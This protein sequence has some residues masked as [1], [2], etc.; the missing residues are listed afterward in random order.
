MSQYIEN[1]LKKIL[2][3]TTINIGILGSCVSRMVFNSTINKTY[4]NFF[5]IKIDVQRSLFPSLIQDPVKFREEDI[6]LYPKDKNNSV[7]HFFVSRDLNKIFFKEIE[8]KDIDYL[9]ID[10]QLEAQ[11]GI[12]FG[13][14][15]YNENITIT[16]N[17][18]D[19]LEM[20]FY[21]NIK[22]KRIITLTENTE[23]YINLW[24]NSCD[25][26][27][28]RIKQLN[29]NIKIILNPIKQTYKIK[30][31]DGKVIL[32]NE[33]K[34]EC[35]SQNKV[36]KILEEYI[37]DNFEVIKLKQPEVFLNK[38]HMWGL[39][40]VH[41]TDEY[42]Q[43]IFNQLIE[44]VYNDMKNLNQIK[45]SM[46]KLQENDVDLD[47]YYFVIDSENLNLNSKLYG[48]TIINNK[49]YTNN[50][51]NSIF[52]ENNDADGC[53][54]FINRKNKDELVISQDFI[55]SYGIYLYQN[56]DYFAISNSFL[57][58]VEYL[59][60]KYPLSLNDDYVKSFTVTDLVSFASVETMVNEIKEVP[61]NSKI[62]INI[63]NKTFEIKKIDY[64]ENSI[65]LSSPE[66]IEELDK[67]FF[68][69]I[70]LI[71][72]LKKENYKIKCDLSGGFDTRLTILLVLCSNIDLSN[73]RIHSLDDQNICHPEDFEIATQISKKF[74]FKLNKPIKYNRTKLD[75]TSTIKNSFYAK[76]GFHK[77]MY[78]QYYKNDEPIITLS[79]N[80]GENLRNYY[81]VP[82]PDFIKRYENSAKNRWSDEF[83]EPTRNILNRTFKEL[84]KNYPENI[85]KSND[86][87]RLLYR[88][89]RTRIHF[90]KQTAER[91]FGN[92]LHINPLIDSNLYKITVNDDYC[93]DYML[94][95]ALIFV[96]YCPE[97][98]EF[99]FEGNRK[100]KKSTIEYAKKINNKYPLERKSAKIPDGLAPNDYLQNI[101]ESEKFKNKYLE[102]YEPEIY[103]KIIE[104]IQV[105]KHFPLTNVYPAISIMKIQDYCKESKNSKKEF[106]SNNSVKKSLQ[107]LVNVGFSKVLIPENYK[108]KSIRS[109]GVLFERENTEIGI[110]EL[111]RKE[112]ELNSYYEKSINEWN[113]IYGNTKTKTFSIKNITLKSVSI[114][115]EEKKLKKTYF[116]KNGI[117]YHIFERNN[118]NKK[119]FDTLFNSVMFD[120]ENLWSKL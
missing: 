84:E 37:C 14:S 3:D 48:F 21:K 79:G 11:Y 60:N 93:D 105:R 97:L 55:G 80:G 47:D 65:S 69:Y 94:L 119:A 53:Y 28:K 118:E 26:V 91:F 13:T 18:N 96:R 107:E 36:L 106:D 103:D 56:D 112:K 15:Q 75:I 12:L 116:K 22:N 102:Y 1:K 40:R 70:K 7:K 43:S 57:K 88:D 34:N 5:N 77:E 66:G 44:I 2:N 89:I 35:D 33:W 61:R 99:K 16:Y 31:D 58:L 27:F 39:C 110:F 92:D 74:N 108:I 76:L 63:K 52:K 59:K 104:D 38:N 120:F 6:T 81:D 54:V 98:L 83:R 42:Y 64:Q 4:K 100:I 49:I 10:L 71:N 19:L 25:I 30:N 24:K 85:K 90:G 23:E 95:V 86:I 46:Y 78:F 82:A 115:N 50:N 62:N 101:F 20:N 68:K 113:K 87:P 8:T 117:G 45:T 41:Y 114:E 72:S 109:N 17:T 32:K 29:P 51:I 9:L 67:W 73:I 111:P